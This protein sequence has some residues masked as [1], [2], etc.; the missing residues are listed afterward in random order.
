MSF[1]FGYDPCLIRDYDILLRK[2]KLSSPQNDGTQNP[3]VA[4]DSSKVAQ[5]SR[6]LAF[7]VVTKSHEPPSISFLFGIRL[8]YPKR[9]YIEV[10]R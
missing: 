10:S 7:Q 2:G 9:N 5:N 6:S 4:H 1:L 8:Y 3:Q